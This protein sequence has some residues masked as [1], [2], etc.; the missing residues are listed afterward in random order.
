MT[1]HYAVIGNPIA[2]SKS[3]QI[4]AAFAQ[5]AGHDIR[6]D[7]IEG[8]LGG[9]AATV[10]AFRAQGGLGLNVTVPFKLD[11]LAYATHASEAAR[12]CG[13]A[14]ALKCDGDHVRADNFDGVGLTRDVT[15]NLGHTIRARRVLILG[16]GGATRGMLLPFL[17]EQPEVLVIANRSLDKAQALSTLVANHGRVHACEYTDLIGE[18]FDLIFNATSASL[19]GQPLPLPDSL[20]KPTGLAYDLAYGKGL[21][22]F[23]RQARQAGVTALADG[24][25]MLVEQAAEAFV[26]WRGVRPD[27]APVIQA[28]T[29]PLN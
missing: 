8:P 29:V 7:K 17:A 26:W 18:S 4:H 22:P 13:A 21:T 25:G 12:L 20:F 3:P 23:L 19:F 11:A 10:D 16:A 2:H 5:A 28:L 1:D 15:H 24:V 9:F 14:N 27:S 6:Y